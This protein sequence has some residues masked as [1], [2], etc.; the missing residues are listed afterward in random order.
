V[1]NC[2]AACSA[3]YPNNTVVTLAVSAG[4]GYIFVGWS[5]A[6]SGLGSCAVTMNAARS[7]TAVFT[8]SSG[9]R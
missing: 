4:A 5:G 3:S 9:R 7:V 2:G 6:C 8:S 1:I